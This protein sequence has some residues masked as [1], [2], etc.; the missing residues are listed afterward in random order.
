MHHHPP[1]SAVATAASR[2]QDEPCL[3]PGPLAGRSGPA[4]LVLVGLVYLVFAQHITLVRDPVSVGAGFWP[5]A[6]VLVS[7]LLALPT[8][9]WGWALGGVALAEATTNLVLG[10]DLLPMVFWVSGNLVVGLVGAA[11]VR[12]FSQR[13]GVLVPL[14]NVVRF[15]GFAVVAGP[16]VGGTLGTIGSVLAAGNPFVDVWV[17]YVIGD[18][19][20]VLVVAPA[21][22]A[23]STGT[24]TARRSP[25]EAGA[26][27]AVLAVVG[28]LTLQ[29][30]DAHWALVGPY[31]VMPLLTWAAMR[32]GMRG[33]SLA[34]LAMALVA[35]WAIATGNGP[36]A[37]ATQSVDG[38]SVTLLQVLLAI[39]A[40]SAYVIAALVDDLADRRDV[41]RS[42]WH[43]AHHDQLT[44]LP[45][46]QLLQ[47]RVG[48]ALQRQAGR[49]GGVAL[50]VCDLDDFKVVNDGLGHQAGDAVLLEVARRL[51]AAVREDDVVARLGADEFVVVLEAADD[52]IVANLTDRLLRVVPDPYDLPDGQQ[53]VVGVTIGVAASAANHD[54][55]ALLRDADATLYHAKRQ[56]RGRAEHFDAQVRVEVLERLALPQQLRAGFSA[57]ELFCL[58]QAEVEL[59]SGQVFG[60][61][62]LVRWQHPDRGLL[63]PDR[64]VPFAEAAGL[65]DRLFEHVLEQTLEAQ[66]RWATVL[67]F[68]P[69][70]SVNL[71]PYQLRDELL[72]ATVALALTRA[73]APADG[74]WL[75]I[76]E[77]AIADAGATSTLHELRDLGV[78]LAIDDFGTGWSSL[79][80]LS[81][82]PCDLLKIDRSFIAPLEPGNHAEHL[83]RAT[84]QMAHALGIPTVAEGIETE[85]QL[86][87]LRHLGCDVGQGYL[88]AK[89]LIA[90]LAIDEVA[91]DGRWTGRG[92]RVG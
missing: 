53:V 72:P 81:E 42:L 87:L 71:S 66:G 8:R 89:P 6:G 7:A 43:Q 84:I 37:L 36:V 92:S 77:S 74:L 18:A 14:R 50:I 78:R 40:G 17:K 62:S 23:W 69:S 19:L 45:N 52:E 88:F 29:H 56:G 25:V 80:R 9:R 10:Y 38:Q 48:E 24:R 2:P 64:F 82:F 4:V 57:G 86:D 49:E 11:L 54:A 26:L 30:W 60:F 31:L 12:A 27:A 13:Y 90:P 75:E 22:L 35:N 67:G 28:I 63:T 61:E 41:E 34:V 3:P 20:G 15:I 51:R 44:G 46:R 39:T 33:V 55:E 59:D 58:H 16:L 32:F 83:V 47:Q 91:P 5:A 21:L 76:T 1:S 65:A 85:A 73:G 79:A 68:R 70:V